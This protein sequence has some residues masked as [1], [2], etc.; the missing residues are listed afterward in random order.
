MEDIIFKELESAVEKLEDNKKEEIIEGSK[1]IYTESGLYKYLQRN[2]E[3]YNLEDGANLAKSKVDFI[4]DSLSDIREDQI[5]TSILTKYLYYLRLLKRLERVESEKNDSNKIE[6]FFITP[7]KFKKGDKEDVNL[8]LLLRIGNSKFS[9]MLS[10]GNQKFEELPVEEVR[11]KIKDK[12]NPLI[13]YRVP[14]QK[15]T[16]PMTEEERDGKIDDFMEYGE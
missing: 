10:S 2:K 8:I 15:E 6:D 4:L 3:K 13:I 16:G 14:Y 9:Y 12:Q 7:C 1:I 5:D 11:N